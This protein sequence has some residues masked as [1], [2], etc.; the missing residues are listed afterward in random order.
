MYVIVDSSD[1]GALSS[2]SDAWSEPGLSAYDVPL[3]RS[4]GIG[5]KSA[6]RGKQ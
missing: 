2:R 6:R 1:Q 5:S 3:I 4:E